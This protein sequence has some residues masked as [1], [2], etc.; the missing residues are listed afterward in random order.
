MRLVG[1]IGGTRARFALSPAPGRLVGARTLAVADFPGPEAAIRAY[2][3]RAPVPPEVV[4]A[5]ATPVEGDEIAFTN[6][7]WRFRASALAAALGARRLAVVNDFTAHALALPALG[8]EDLEPLGGGVPDP[9]RPRLVLGPGTGLGTA[10]LV[11]C[12][13]FARPFPTEAGHMSLAPETARERAILAHLAAH[14]D[15][16]SRERLV[17]GPGLVTLVE[18]L[19]ALEG[20]AVPAADPP[21]VVAAARAGDPLC[22]EAV[23]L[24]TG[25]L[26]A[27]AGDLALA[28]GARGG[29][30]LVGG[31]LAA[32]GELFDPA[33]FRRRFEGKGRLA[34]W[35]AG[36]PVHRVRRTDTGLLGASRY[37]FA[38]AEAIA[39]VVVDAGAGDREEVDSP[40][41]P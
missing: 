38:H 33:L 26:G 24:F 13:T 11:P 39:G 14:R 25:L 2:L 23:D 15:H 19:A 35:L 32:L 16:V 20:V 27:Y 5:V 10:V 8:A 37:D 22:R 29:V 4:L 21:A 9:R 28:H 31:L 36:V 12:G 18:T 40:P 7:P 17:S 30:H 41:H 3:G 1:D 34:S 6:A